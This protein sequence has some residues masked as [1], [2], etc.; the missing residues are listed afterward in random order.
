MSF[1]ITNWTISAPMASVSHAEII[2]LTDGQLCVIKLPLSVLLFM[3]IIT[4]LL[5]N[6]VLRLCGAA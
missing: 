3:Q 5:Y 1:S 2:S 6:R 4:K